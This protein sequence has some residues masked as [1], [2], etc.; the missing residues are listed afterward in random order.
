MQCSFLVQLT[1]HSLLPSYLISYTSVKHLL[2]TSMA[3]KQSTKQASG[4]TQVSR[5]SAF[6]ATFLPVLTHTAA[7]TILPE[8]ASYDEECKGGYRQGSRY[9]KACC[10]SL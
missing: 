3:P 10:H 5:N 9:S 4:L 6:P 1:F 7:Y 8:S 2:Y